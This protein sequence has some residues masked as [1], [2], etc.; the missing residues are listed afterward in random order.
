MEIE[1][2]YEFEMC[3][4]SRQAPASSER[5]LLVRPSLLVALISIL[6]SVLL[7]TLLVPLLALLV[8]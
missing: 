7:S 5:N 3:S 2:E 8:T 4:G 1:Y 6:I